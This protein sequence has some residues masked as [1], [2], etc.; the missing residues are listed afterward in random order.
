MPVNWENEKTEM[1][2]AQIMVLHSECYSYLEI[3]VQSNLVSWRGRLPRGLLF[4]CFVTRGLL[5][6]A[7]NRNSF[8]AADILAVFRR[9]RR[10]TGR[11]S[12]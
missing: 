5:G 12:F 9:K 1:G 2:I 11:G 6:L 7:R 3:E 4:N 10:K 8:H